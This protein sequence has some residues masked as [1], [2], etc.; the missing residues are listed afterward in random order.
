MKNRFKGLDMMDR[1]PEE[2]W[3]EIHDNVQEAGIKTIAKKKRNAKIW[4]NEALH[5]A[6]ERREAK[7]KGE[8]E[9]YNH[10]NTDFQRRA[11]RDN[12]AFLSDQCKEMKENNRMG[13][14]RDLFMKIGDTR[15]IFDAKMSTI[16]DRSG[17]DITEAE[18]IKIWQKYTEKLNK[19]IFM[20]QITMMI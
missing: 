6:K 4:H 19:I 3:T 10:L 13:K 16:N 20:T 5:I 17:K 7:G 14:T 1:V 11:R 12:K 15:R 2:I 18:D 9:R 8:K